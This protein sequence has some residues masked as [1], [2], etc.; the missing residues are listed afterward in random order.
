M[1]WIVFKDSLGRS[2]FRSLILQD[3]P[4]VLHYN[5]HHSLSSH[6]EVLRVSWNDRKKPTWKE[7]AVDLQSWVH[8]N[9]RDFILTLDNLHPP[10]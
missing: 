6:L 10:K 9:L 5:P 2:S 4:D 8:R 1:V 3:F 7:R